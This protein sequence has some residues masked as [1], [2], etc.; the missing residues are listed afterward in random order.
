[1]VIKYTSRLYIVIKNTSRLYILSLSPAVFRDLSQH[2]RALERRALAA[3]GPEAVVRA[4]LLGARARVA[5]WSR[6]PFFIQPRC[7][8]GRRKWRRK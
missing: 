5:T 3:P 7:I 2:A 4:R 1:M 8:E 6:N